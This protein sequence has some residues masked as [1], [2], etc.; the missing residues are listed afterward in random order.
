VRIDVR[1]RGSGEHALNVH[2]H[3][4]SGVMMDVRRRGGGGPLAA[5]PGA[6]APLAFAPVCRDRIVGANMIRATPR[7]F[8]L[9][10]ALTAPVLP[11]VPAQAGMGPDYVSSDNL[12]L[13]TRLKTTGDGVGGRIVGDHL[14][15]TS[16]KS[17]EI[18][19]IKSD[20]ENPALVNVTTLDVE[21]ENEEVPTNGKLLGIS[22]EISACRDITAGLADPTAIVAGGCL[23]LYD[24]SDQTN[25]VFLKSVAGAGDHTQSCVY[26]CQYF[27]G[28]S[29]TIVDARDPADAKTIGNWKDGIGE[30]AFKTGC[31][32][33]R[34]I[35]PGVVLASCQPT[36]LFSVRPQD[37][38]S[39]LQPVV[40]VTGSNEDER[41]IHSSRWPRQGH[42]KFMLSGGETNFQPQCDDTV[43]AFM[44]WDAS[45]ARDGVGGFVK[46]AAF[47]LLSEVRPSGGQYLDGRAPNNGLGCSAHWFNE[48][49]EFRDG[50]AVALAEY[51]NGTRLL[52]ITP[53]GK[54]VEQGFFLPL[55]GST[56]A[57]HFHPNG[58]VIYAVDYTR[59]VDVL[60]YTGPSYAPGAGGVVT[61]EPGTT[62][63]TAGAT[64][65]TAG[66]PAGGSGAPCATAAGFKDAGARRSG[67]GVRFT[68]T[69]RQARS[70]TAEVFQQ[71]SGRRLMNNPLRARFTGRRASFTWNGRDARGHRLT[72]GHYFVRYTMKL[73]GGKRDVRRVTLVRRN[74]RFSVARD[75][76]QRTDC[77][78]FSSFKLSS[79][80]FGG[81]RNAPLGISYRLARGADAVRVE[82]FA[83]T[84]RLRTFSGGTAANRS[85]SFRLPAAGLRRGQRVTIRATVINGSPVAA[86]QL[87]AVRL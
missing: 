53:E 56:S 68:V 27:Y 47:K 30:E 74:G 23:N 17:L 72:D 11:A 67:R 80:V 46:G 15:V 58:K 19:D 34:E 78:L 45:S 66:A 71:S 54:I 12:E 7:S 64:P 77:G 65:G 69:R 10:L 61:P 43:G 62:A 85:Y 75:F 87:Y 3:P 59:G 22:G 52:Q 42:D 81:A 37:G 8:A 21:F 82:A 57:P 33:V 41:F 9:A 13:V 38:G 36:M 31:H 76:Y 35:Q 14:Y 4:V 70:F 86:Q 60:R 5:A 29:G 25:P 16:T 83:G 44:V 39:L 1:R 48:H 32:H 6:V 79:S 18:Y 24:V 50:G 20:P 26:D 40:L 2:Q 28:S 84:R 55:A 73:A 49:P 63:G 51:E